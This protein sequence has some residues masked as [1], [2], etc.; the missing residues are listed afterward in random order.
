[1]C[2]WAEFRVCMIYEL[3]QKWVRVQPTFLSEGKLHKIARVSKTCKV[4]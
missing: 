3:R 4:C 1:M 2:L